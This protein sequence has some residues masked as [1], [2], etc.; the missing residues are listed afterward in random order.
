MLYGIKGNDFYQQNNHFAPCPSSTTILLSVSPIPPVRRAYDLT[1]QPAAVTDLNEAVSSPVQTVHQSPGVWEGLVHWASLTDTQIL[2]CTQLRRL[3]IMKSYKLSLNLH[4]HISKYLFLFFIDLH[5]G[6]RSNFEN[7]V[8][9]FIGSVS[10]TEKSIPT[11]SPMLY[12]IGTATHS[13]W[14]F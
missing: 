4:Q 7:F 6:K 10:E 1:S 11:E 13:E 12:W 3:Y 14:K 9:F 5:H 8:F 2:P